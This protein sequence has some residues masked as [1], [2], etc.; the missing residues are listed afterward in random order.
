MGML[1][2]DRDEE[3][4]FGNL[5]T[6]CQENDLSDLSH[7][8]LVR[9]YKVDESKRGRPPLLQA[10]FCPFCGERYV[11]TPAQAGVGGPTASGDEYSPA[12]EAPSTMKT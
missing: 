8:C 12:E 4:F 10:T 3:E 11:R 2:P 7:T 9:L 1:N 5:Y 6:R